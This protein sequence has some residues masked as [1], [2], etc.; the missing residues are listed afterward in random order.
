MKHPEYTIVSPQATPALYKMSQR[1]DATARPWR[2]MF[3]ILNPG[4]AP[5]RRFWP[6]YRFKRNVF[7]K[8][9]RPN[10]TPQAGMC[11]FRPPKG[12]GV[13]D[14]LKVN[15]NLTRYYLGLDRISLGLLYYSG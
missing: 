9:S 11:A 6:M 5:D 2:S 12:T 4:M 13:F 14:G 10:Y 8:A 15:K 7:L 1:R 3:T